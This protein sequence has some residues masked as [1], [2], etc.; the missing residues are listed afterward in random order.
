MIPI[1]MEQRTSSAMTRP[2]CPSSTNRQLTSWKAAGAAAILSLLAA[3]SAE[4]HRKRVDQRAYNIVHEK[5][6][7]ALGRTEPFTVEA[8]A[9]A[10]RRRLLLSQDLPYAFKASLGSEFLPPVPHWPE[11]RPMADTN[12]VPAMPPILV[13]TLND[14]LQ[15]AARNSREYQGQKEDVFRAAL[16]LDLERDQFRASFAALISGFYRYDGSQ[17]DADASES[18]GLNTS[19]GMAQNLMNGSSFALRLGWDLVQLLEPENF[20]SRSV[21]GDA[22]ISIPLMRGAGRHIAAEPLLQAER[23]VTYAIYDFERFK[24]SFAVTVANEYLGVLQSADQVRNA[25]ENYRGLIASTRRARRLLDA[26]DLPPIQVDQSIQ[27]ELNAR[28]RW[29]SARESQTA[30]LDSFKAL[31]GLPVDATV[32]LDHREFE[33]LA[34]FARRITERATVIDVEEEIPPADAAIELQEPS[35]AGAGPFE[36]EPEQAIQIAFRN[37]MDLRIAEG[38]VSDAQRGVVVAADRLRTEL[39]LFGTARVTGEDLGDLSLDQGDYSALLALELPLERTAEAIAYRS[40]YLQLQE[41]V[42]GLQAL[43]DAIKQDVRQR[44]RTLREARETLRIQ[45]LS[46]ELARRRVRGADLNLQAGRVEIRDLLEAQED[47][48]SAQNALTSAAVDYRLAELELQR[49]LDILEVAA[50][51]LWK[52]FNPE[53]LHEQTP[54]G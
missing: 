36:I 1:T 46:V 31:L 16:N 39:T 5:Q 45:A 6:Q 22:S 30:A 35:A 14:A 40:S 13:L 18:V 37:R 15:V 51:G 47:L 28:N 49:D 17:S 23:D 26:G 42:R 34:S 20:T 24:R 38:R 25:E 27:D 43:E 2:T 50:D 32:E 10:L 21:F 33:K 7:I 3:C 9:D 8:P 41:A 53:L 52:E 54:N 48:L 19:A 29:I 12:L 44:L 11:P 4:T